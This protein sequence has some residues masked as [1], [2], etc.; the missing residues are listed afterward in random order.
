MTYEQKFQITGLT[1][2]ACT[3]LSA[4]RI[5]ALPGVDDA[6][7]ELADGIAYV[8]ASREIALAELQ[9]VLAGSQ[10]NAEVFHD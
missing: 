4:R 2:A 3:K 10:Y 8:T 7:V 1:C 9:S 6:Q 5:K